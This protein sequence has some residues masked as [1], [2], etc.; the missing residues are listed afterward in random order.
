MTRVPDPE[1]LFFTSPIGLGHATRDCAV[2]GHLGSFRMRFVTGSGAA[3]MIGGYGFDVLDAY[4]PPDFAVRAGS[5]KRPL[6]WL[7]RYYR[8]YRDCK[9]IARREIEDRRP[10]VIVSDEDFAS[11]AVGQEMGIPTVLITDVLETGFTRGPASVIERKM[12]RSMQEIAS[13]CGAVI[14]PEDGP[15]AGNQRR[16]GPI[17]RGTARTREELRSKF[18]FTG[19][20]ILISAGGTDAGR[21]LIERALQAVAGLDVDVRVV[22]GPLLEARYGRDMGFFRDMHEMVYAADAV[23]SLAGRSTIDEAKFYGTPGIFIPIGDHFEQEANARRAGFSFQD[24][25]RLES[26]VRQLPPRTD[27]APSN[28]AGTAASIIADILEKTNN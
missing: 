14:L 12:N 2:A 28:G 10:S 8:Y 7:W 6:G 16:V 27:A 23:I 1:I 26:L 5:L 25:D 19:R 18:G 9:R 24:I 15:D 11:L 4:R 21:F 3:R 17:V 22:S 13:R 20:T